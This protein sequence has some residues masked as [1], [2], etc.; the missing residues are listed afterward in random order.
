MLNYGAAA[1]TY[2]GYNTDNLM[3]AELT[4]EQKALNIPYDETLFKNSVAADPAK[5]GA[6]SATSSGFSKKSAT[7]SFEGA[8]CVNYYFTPSA[9]V[10][11][12]MTLYIWTPEAYAAA[13]TLTAENAT[14]VPMVAG[15]DGRYFGQVEGIAA[16]RLDE[17][18][19][20]AGVYTDANGNTYCTGIIA[21]SLSKYC[22][23]NAKPGKEMQEL[24]SATAMYGYYAKLY[25][26]K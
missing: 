8:F 6:F 3:N 15:T 24:A 17:T 23:N 5:I 4:A 1:Q 26:T 9:A 19:Y 21:Y 11:G 25:F 10:N 20:V 14:V 16:K 22:I 12:D 2:F 7:V 13:T 18:Y